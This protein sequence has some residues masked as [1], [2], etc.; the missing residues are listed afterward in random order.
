M[1]EAN[2]ELVDRLRRV[3]SYLGKP[4]SSLDEKL[5]GRIDDLLGQARNYRRKISDLK[6]QVKELE[7]KAGENKGPDV[8][9]EDV[10]ELESYRKLGDVET[11]R[12]AVEEGIPAIDALKGRERGDIMRAV[13]DTYGWSA[14]VL[15]ELDALK[16]GSVEVK[17][18]TNKVGD[19]DVTSYVAVVDGKDVPYDDYVEE[20]YQS[21]LPSLTA[22][23]QQ[24]RVEGAPPRRTIRQ[25]RSS[26][27]DDAT[28]V[29]EEKIEA[30]IHKRLSPG[31]LL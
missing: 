12:K 5:V 19:R 3:E 24:R 20:H 11:V 17:K 27:T 1:P 18:V 4:S 15:A 23:Q 16:G 29:T 10:K 2:D 28:V 25:R 26:S 30:D 22:E 6:K 8:S 31:S 7:T 13:A 9:E 21:F 14:S